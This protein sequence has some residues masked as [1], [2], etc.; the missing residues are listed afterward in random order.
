MKV[1]YYFLCYKTLFYII[2]IQ[3]EIIHTILHEFVIFPKIITA[4]SQTTGYGM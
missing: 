2:K 3:I 4:L 1:S